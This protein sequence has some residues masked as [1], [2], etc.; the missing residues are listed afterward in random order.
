VAAA[1]ASAALLASRRP[2]FLSS[3]E[4]VGDKPEAPAAVAEEAEPAKAKP[5]MHVLLQREST[6]AVLQRFTPLHGRVVCERVLVQACIEEEIGDIPLKVLAYARDGVS[7]SL[8]VAFEKPLWP[9][10][11]VPA[12]GMGYPVVPISLR[13]PEPPAPTGAAPSEA[14]AEAAGGSSD[15]GAAGEE[16]EEEEGPTPW[17]M[18]EGLWRRLEASGVLQI[19]RDDQSL[20]C[21][22]SLTDGGS[23]WSGPLPRQDDLAEVHVFS[24]AD[25]WTV[26]A[27]AVVPECG[28]CRFMKAGPCGAEFSAWEDC[29]ER[30]RA[31]DADFVELC[32]PQTLKLKACT[33]RHPEYY[34]MLGGDDGGDEGDDAD[35]AAPPPS[36]S[37]AA[38]AGGGP[39]DASPNGSAPP[40]AAA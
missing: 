29:I 19:E 25:A 20:P 32:G 30:A 2:A 18:T 14:G 39:A 33:D 12:S 5:C 11:R 13:E 31:T 22:V 35:S 15:G 7:Q 6:S 9:T 10:D 34:G 3:E 8:L 38:N 17:E 27:E 40:A 1:S 24:G 16:A 37:A 36:E 4:Q 21:E 23:K 26:L 28:F